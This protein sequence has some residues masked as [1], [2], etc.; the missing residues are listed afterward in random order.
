[1]ETLKINIEQLKK[2]SRQVTGI[3]NIQIGDLFFP[4]KFWNDSI[5]N[6]FEAWD[7]SYNELQY[8]DEIN[9]EF[10]FF[11][12]PYAFTLKGKGESLEVDFIADGISEFK[13]KIN[14]GEFLAEYKIA[15]EKLSD[16][17]KM[18]P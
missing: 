15:K 14:K 12:G 10:T 7:S 9:C 11:D 1:M 2:P 5:L 17:L 6:L 18:L 4:E 3:I 8:S 13:T 16:F